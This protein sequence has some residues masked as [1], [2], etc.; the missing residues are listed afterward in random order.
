MSEITEYPQGTP[1]W[2]DLWTP[3][4]QTSMDFYGAVFGWTYRVGPAEQH[5]FTE[6]LV[7]D[8]TIAGMLTPPG[9]DE[10][11][12]M[13]WTT[14]LSVDD[15]DATV[16]AVTE[17]GGQN[18]TGVITV[19]GTGIRIALATDPTGGLVGVW[20]APGHAGAELANEPGTQAWNELMTPDPAAARTFYAAV[21]GV[22]IG[23]PF[24]RM[25]YTTIKVNGRDVG[26][27]GES[28]DGAPAGWN[29]YFSVAETDGVAALVR[30]NGGS[31]LGEPKDTPYGRMAGCADPHGATFYLMG[32]NAD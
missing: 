32:P 7:K 24:P 23:E 21:F 10:H 14:Y 27:I 26:G 28:D 30:S 2:V 5:S 17:H 4:R 16:A 8:R 19:P 12:P 20:Q 15:V 29:V 1:C 11:T 9:A 22:E 25:D 6:V 13:V 3:D 31:L 18:L